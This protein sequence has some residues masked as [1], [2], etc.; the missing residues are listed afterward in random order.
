[1]GW[2]V[3]LCPPTACPGRARRSRCT[4]ASRATSLFL[5]SSGRSSTR[6]GVFLKLQSTSVGCRS[7]PV[8]AMPGHAHA[9]APGCMLADSTRLLLIRSIHAV[10][11]SAGGPGLLAILVPLVA[12]TVR[13]AATDDG[14]RAMRMVALLAGR[15]SDGGMHGSLVAVVA[16][17][18]AAAPPAAARPAAR[19][20]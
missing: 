1:M 12:S 5:L 20:R 18:L 8:A 2:S 4:T 9:A 13:A 17:H 14:D 16:A 3:L 10:H 15:S 6:G 7:A 19:A 11:A